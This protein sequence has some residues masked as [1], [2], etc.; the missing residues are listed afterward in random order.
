MAT[1]I[2]ML[3]EKAKDI[4][5]KGDIQ[6]LASACIDAYAVVV[7]QGWYENKQ[8]GTSEVDG[9]FVY[10]FKNVAPILDLD[11]DKY[12][13]V[14]PSS[15]VRLPHEMGINYVSLMAN[16]NKP[17]MRLNSGSIGMWSNLKS[18]V[19][20]GHQTYY[21]EGIRMYFP[22][23]TNV[24]NGNILLKLSIALD[25]VDVDETLNIPPDM[26]SMIVDMVV[27][28]YQPKPEVKPDTLQ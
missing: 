13:A 22:K 25:N 4:L 5:G 14:I 18:N 17:F 1:S 6:A 15:Y 10:T 11:L 20:G 23:M 24:S 19:L 12:Y 8:D 27:A 28:K 2:F 9:A 7:K 21:V 3:A 26:A 16:Q